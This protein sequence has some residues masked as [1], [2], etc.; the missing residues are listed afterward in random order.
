ML[1]TILKSKVAVQVSIQI[2]DAFVAMLKFIN[3]SLIEQKYIN[4]LV[5]NHVTSIKLLQESF[6]QFDKK[7]K[8]I[9]SFLKARFMMIIL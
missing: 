9:I 4:H 6:T 3:E 2:M 7:K 1:S 5:L 8:I